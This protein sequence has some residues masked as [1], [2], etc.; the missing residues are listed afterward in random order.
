MTNKH[1][2]LWQCKQYASFVNLAHLFN[3]FRELTFTAQL[4]AFLFK[5]L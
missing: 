2:L 1:T 3:R 5:T 4:E